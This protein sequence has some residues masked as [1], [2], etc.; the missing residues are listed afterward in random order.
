MEENVLI[1]DNVVLLGKCEALAGNFG[2]NIRENKLILVL[3]LYDC[4]VCCICFKIFAT[5]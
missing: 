3:L 2:N 1:G 5:D 4:R